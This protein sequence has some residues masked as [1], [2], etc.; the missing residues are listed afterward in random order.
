MTVPVSI[1]DIREHM[2]D[3]ETGPGRVDPDST[4]FQSASTLGDRSFSVSAY[5][6][7]GVST[8]EWI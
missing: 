5:G 2:R 7:Q 3:P 6:P 4:V 8:F 1:D